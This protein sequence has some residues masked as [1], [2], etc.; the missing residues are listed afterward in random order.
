MLAKVVNKST[1]Q[2]SSLTVDGL[3]KIID[4]FEDRML[5]M[6]EVRDLA[7]TSEIDDERYFIDNNNW[8]AMHYHDKDNYMIDDCVFECTPKSYG[9]LAS[10]LIESHLS[11]FKNN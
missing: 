11:Y 3:V 7:T 6:K 10:Q 8:F 4:E 1:K 2:W 5:S 9:E